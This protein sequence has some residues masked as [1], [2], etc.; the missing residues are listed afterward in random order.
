MFFQRKKVAAKVRRS[1]NS[2]EEQYFRRSQTLTGSKSSAVRAAGEKT[3]TLQS[4]RLKRQELHRKRQLYGILLGFVLSLCLGIFYLMTQYISAVDSVEFSAGASIQSSDAQQYRKAVS[5]YLLQHPA[6]RF[7]FAL[8]TERLTA[9]IAKRHPEVVGVSVSDR[10][11]TV[12]L[13]QPVAVWIVRDVHYFVDKDGRTFQKNYYAAPSVSVRDN[14]GASVAGSTLA[15]RSFL[16][17][18]GRMVALLGESGLGKVTEASLPPNT[19][20]E[21]DFKLEGRGY[22]IKTHT[23]RDPAQEVEDIKRVVGYLEQRSITPQY[24][25]VRVSGRAYYK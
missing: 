14:S 21:I 9:D 11:F 19:T 22:T 13:R 5:E 4:D 17:F 16:H 23:D 18:L 20:R 10:T 8:N 7:Y 6:E 24:I 1:H 12:E 2:Q 15:S 25:D 3:A